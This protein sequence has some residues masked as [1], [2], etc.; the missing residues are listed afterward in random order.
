MSYATIRCSNCG[1]RLRNE[2]ERRR[3]KCSTC[4]NK[5]SNNNDALAKGLLVAGAAVVGFVGGVVATWWSNSNDTEKAQANGNNAIAN[6]NNQNNQNN[7]NNG[8]KQNKGIHH[9]SISLH[10]VF[11][12]CAKHW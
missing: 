3:L 6:Q 8:N 12:P 11:Y 1:K 2:S 5:R 10:H 4:N 9:S 7:V